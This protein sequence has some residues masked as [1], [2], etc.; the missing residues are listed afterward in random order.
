MI[1]TIYRELH[2]KLK[3][4]VWLKHIALDTNQLENTEK[5]S[6]WN[7]PAV[8]IS[9]ETLSV[10]LLSNNVYSNIVNITFK[11]V[12]KDFN[13]D[14][15]LCLDYSQMLERKLNGFLGMIKYMN[16][17]SIDQ[18][19]NYVYSSIFQINFNE[20]LTDT[21]TLKTATF[22]DINM[23]LDNVQNI[24]DEEGQG[25]ASDGINI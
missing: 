18:D 12:M 24:S 11:F 14:Q 9:F 15:L 8:F 3:E 17:F 19:M 2:T 23:D 4:L 21:S 16:N 5:N 22:A 6:P 20:D 10:N 13:K 1:S 7:T 25:F